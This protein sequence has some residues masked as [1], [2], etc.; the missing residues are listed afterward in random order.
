MLLAGGDLD[1][2]VAPSSVELVAESPTPGLQRTQSP[3]LTVLMA[4]L[5]MGEASSPPP[6]PQQPPQQQAQ[7]F[8]LL[9]SLAADQPQLP[10]VDLLSPGQA[11]RQRA[12][13][14]MSQ[15]EEAG[16]AAGVDAAAAQARERA[17]EQARER[18]GYGSSSS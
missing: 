8:E 3:G 14:R 5:E 15:H 11:A 10:D 17:R 12:L 2:T 1:A 4:Q 16:G 18:A 6:P 9:G 7:P 13:L